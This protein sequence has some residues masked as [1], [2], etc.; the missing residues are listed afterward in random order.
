MITAE[1]ARE[2]LAL[3]R[4]ENKYK[5]EKNIKL[6]LK[7]IDNLIK[8]RIKDGESILEYDVYIGSGEVNIILDIRD[9]L[10]DFGYSAGYE[11]YNRWGRGV[12]EGV[13]TISWEEEED[14]E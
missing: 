6:L 11:S 10:I 3:V 14:S 2:E 12:C 1:Q 5:K 13:L 9:I 7:K 8:S 4:A